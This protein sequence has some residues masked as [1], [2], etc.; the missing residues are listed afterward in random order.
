MDIL[1][2][3]INS[4]F[5]K[6]VIQLTGP[7]LF[8]FI[9]IKFVDILLL[10][11]T[12]K[13]ASLF[14]LFLSYILTIF[15][16]ILRILRIYLPVK[17]NMET[18]SFCNFVKLFISTRLLGW[19]SNVFISDFANAIILMKSQENKIRI[20]NIFIM[21]R[22]MDIISTLIIFSISFYIN[23]HYLNTYF[24][25]SN[26]KL[27]LS[28]M[29][30]I[31]TICVIVLLRKKIMFYLS[32]LISTAKTF[33]PD[34]AL[35]SV[36]IVISVIFSVIFDARALNIVIPVSYLLLCYTA[37]IAITVLPISISGIGTREIAYIFLL[38]IININPEKAVALSLIEFV[39]IP[40]LSLLTMY[41]IS[42]IGVCHE[43]RYNR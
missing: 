8:L 24:Y 29:L 13:S 22:V 21:N 25:F 12:L 20:S 32:D 19:I 31:V 2:K 43:N 9:F 36:S 7:F 27:L 6:K 16:F 33:I 38:E 23:A 26:K 40:L 28:S 15:I 5:V 35:I 34:T 30:I 4:A 39:F 17:K 10:V 11:E 37:G 14:Y 42:I 18:I 1:R 3:L 41:I